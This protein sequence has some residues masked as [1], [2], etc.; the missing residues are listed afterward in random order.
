MNIIDVSEEWTSVTLDEEGTK[1]AI[2][3]TKAGLYSMARLQVAWS[4]PFLVTAV[5]D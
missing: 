2:T 3:A 4:P 5:Q 1:K